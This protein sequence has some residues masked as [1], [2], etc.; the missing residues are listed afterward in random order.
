MYVEG[1]VMLQWPSLI[2]Y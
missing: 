1:F 2:R